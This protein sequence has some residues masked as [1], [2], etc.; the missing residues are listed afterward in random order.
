MSHFEVG[1]K[2]I[3]KKDYI[4]FKQGSVGVVTKVFNSRRALVDVDFIGGS[5]T[6]YPERLAIYLPNKDFSASDLN[7]M[8][9]EQLISV[10]EQAGKLLSSNKVVLYSTDGLHW[11]SE[12]DSTPKFKM[13]YHLNGGEI[14]DFQIESVGQVYAEYY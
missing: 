4:D 10:I 8:S 3:L 13:T 7:S 11:A 14:T 12:T 2:V 1:D 6:M 9:R 5:T